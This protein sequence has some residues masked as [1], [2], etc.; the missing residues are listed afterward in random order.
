MTCQCGDGTV[1]FDHAAKKWK[2]ADHRCAKPSPKSV[3]RG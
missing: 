3:G 2:T 1:W